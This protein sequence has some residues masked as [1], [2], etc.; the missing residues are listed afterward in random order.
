[1]ADDATKRGEGVTL[2]AAAW[3]RALLSNSLGRYQDAVTAA[4]EATESHRE[5]GYVTLCSLAELVTAAA[6]AGRP[7]AAAQALARLTSMTEASG[8]DWALGVTA[9]CRAMLAADDSAEPD[10]REAIARLERTRIRGELARAH[11]YYGE[12]LRRRGR[13]NDARRELH[14]AHSMFTERGMASFAALAA[15]ELGATGEKVRE[16]AHPESNTLTPQETQ[17]ARLVRDGLSNAEIA[18]RLFISPRTVEWH[19]GKVFAKLGVTSRRQLR[20]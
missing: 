9:G 17:I 11:L 13:R 14:T 5:M 3:L 8:T 16:A 2:I 1:M 6:H 18:G 15:R 10:F 12:W 7:A 20:R 4:L 19:L